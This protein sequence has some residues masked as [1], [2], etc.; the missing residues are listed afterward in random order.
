MDDAFKIYVEQLRDGHVEKLEE[1]FSSEFLDIHE[2]E[3]SFKGP[4]AFQGEAYLANDDLVM[5][6]SAS[7][8]C[9]LPCVICNKP[10]Q[11]E[12]KVENHYH[13]APLAEVKSGIYHFR[14]ILRE[15]ILLEVPQFAECEGGCPERKEIAQYLKEPSSKD[16]EEE[17][18]YQ[19]FAD[20]K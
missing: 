14:E 6:F 3:L 17:E 2:K 20:L 18:G 11:Q 19:P 7:C 12:L 13:N 1:S 10:V 9:Q 15:I 16:E 4:V 8:H 5:R